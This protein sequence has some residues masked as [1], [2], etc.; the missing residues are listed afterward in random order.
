MENILDIIFDARSEEFAKIQKF[1]NFIDYI[2]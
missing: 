2:I 1:L